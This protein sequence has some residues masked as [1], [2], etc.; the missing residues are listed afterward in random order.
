MEGRIKIVMREKK[1]GFIV[2][3][4]QCEYFFHASAVPKDLGFESLTVGER[5]MFE[6]NEGPKGKRAEGVER[7]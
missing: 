4:D 3:D 6:P 5:V 7:V 1:F 2:G